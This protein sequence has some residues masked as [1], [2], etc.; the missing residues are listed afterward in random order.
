MTHLRIATWNVNAFN[1][2]RAADKL[3]LLELI[4]WDVALLQEVGASTFGTFTSATFRGVHA[5][6]LVEDYQGAKAHGVAVLVKDGTS[7]AEHAL[8]PI[9]ESDARDDPRYRARLLHAR[10]RVGAMELDVASFHA[11]HAAASDPEKARRFRDSKNAVYRALDAW[12]RARRGSGLVVG[13]DG[14]VWNDATEAMQLPP[15][16]ER[17]AERSFHD[18][19]ATHGLRDALLDHLRHNRPDL[20]ERRMRLGHDPKDGAL[21]VTYQRSSNNHPKVNR[22]DRIYVSEGFVVRNVDTLYDE[23]LTVGSDH[24]MVVAELQRRD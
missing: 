23:A 14:N 6:P 4:D 1:P 18:P 16:D 7:I 5:L 22:M 19:A 13:M 8:I 9:G 2:A 3:R 17:Y 10:L 11:P 15:D 12:V 20:L 21:A 24:A